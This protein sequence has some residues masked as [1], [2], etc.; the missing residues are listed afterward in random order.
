MST[1]GRGDVQNVSDPGKFLA[2]P[3]APTIVSIPGDALPEYNG[4]EE[5][6]GPS[7][8]HGNA[9]AI[10][11]Q[12]YS[13][14][15]KAGSRG[16]LVTGTAIVA[17][18]GLGTLAYFFLPPVSEKTAS[19]PQ[20]GGPTQASQSPPEAPMRQTQPDVW[21]SGRSAAS[22][23]IAWPDPSPTVS[24]GRTDSRVE[25][26]PQVPTAAEGKSAAIR[27]P[28]AAPQNRNVLFLQRPGVNVRS[29]PSPTGRV[30]GSARK[31]T[32]L[33]V[34][35]RE[36]EWVQVESGSL[37]GWINSRFVGLEEPR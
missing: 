21:P 15:R 13:P 8:A 9:F 22:P 4:R 23:T 1:K 10:V 36:G 28:L 25:S 14:D 29:S 33:E 17:T 34:T 2:P 16:K 26:A 19:Q 35:N 12:S 18:L 20:A 37:K 5:S 3:L 24:P 27:P 32:R 30:V 7:P 11:E 31:G 6:F